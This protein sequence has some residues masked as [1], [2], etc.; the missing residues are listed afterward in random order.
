VKRPI[1]AAIATLYICAAAAGETPDTQPSTRLSVK[2][3]DTDGSPVAGADVGLQPRIRAGLASHDGYDLL[4]WQ[5]RWSKQQTDAAGTA[6]IPLGGSSQRIFDKFCLVARHAERKLAVVSNIGTAQLDTPLCVTLLPERIV[7]GEVFCPELADRGMTIR[8]I[9]V[10]VSCEGKTVLDCNSPHPE[11]RLSLP[12]GDFEFLIDGQTNTHAIKRP[13]HVDAGDGPLALGCIELQASNMA[14]LVGQPAPE[15]PSI[16][17]WKNGSP[18]TLAELRGKVVLLDFWGYWC[19]PCVSEMPKLFDLHD[20]Y[21]GR[22]LVIIG[23]HADAR[24]AD[25]PPVNSPGELDNLMAERRNALWQGRDFPF[26]VAMIPSEIMQH[27]G[28]KIENRAMSAAAERYG[29][30]SYPSYVLIDRQGKVAG[31]FRVDDEGIALLEKLLAE[32]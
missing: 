23:V 21:H 17:A 30:W 1:L 13:V 22:G 28:G 29:V 7:E 31:Q 8:G 9:S 24:Y 6:T 15:I 4:G 26:P 16:I 14:L 25:E 10:S 20:K 18:G 19:G 11:F 5:L 32:K 2:A 12:P 3:I 27:R